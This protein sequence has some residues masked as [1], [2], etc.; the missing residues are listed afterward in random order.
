MLFSPVYIYI[1]PRSAKLHLRRAV[2]LNPPGPFPRYP[3]L[4]SKRIAPV[5]PVDLCA[6]ER[7]LREDRCTFERGS[8]EESVLLGSLASA[9]NKGLITPLESALTEFSPLTSLE[10]AHPK[11]TGGRGWFGKLETS[12]NAKDLGMPPKRPLRILLCL[13]IDPQP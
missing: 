3:C 1:E 9:G 5:S 11:N 2:L 6:F 7:C 13:E 12:R 10:S 8:R 4:P